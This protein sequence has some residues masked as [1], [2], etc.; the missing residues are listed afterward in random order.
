MAGKTVSNVSTTAAEMAA[1]VVGNVAVD[2]QTAGK[3]IVMTVTV[4]PNAEPKEL[5]TPE[6]RQLV[7]QNAAERQFRNKP[8][9]QPNRYRVQ[10]EIDGKQVDRITEAINEDEAFAKV[11][12]L[13]GGTPKFPKRCGRQ[14]TLVG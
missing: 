11:C 7:V 6:A 14:V 8:A 4:D 9:P 2:N 5:P 1:T 10:F 12:D 13:T 3:E